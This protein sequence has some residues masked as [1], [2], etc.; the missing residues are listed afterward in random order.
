LSIRK[1]PPFSGIGRVDDATPPGGTVAHRLGVDV[2]EFDLV[3]GFTKLI[4]D[5]EPRR[6]DRDLPHPPPDLCFCSLRLMSAI[7]V[8]KCTINRDVS[9]LPAPDS[10]DKMIH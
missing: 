3:V 7:W 4:N 6:P 10:P 9:V 5:V 1:H 8:R 2:H